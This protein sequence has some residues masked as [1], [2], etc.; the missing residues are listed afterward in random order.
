MIKTSTLVFRILVFGVIVLLVGVT[1]V[2]SID[3]FVDRSYTKP[4]SNP[5]TS[6]TVEVLVSRYKADGTVEKNKVI[7]SK[8]KALEFKE[9]Y[10]KIDDAENSF[11]LL[12]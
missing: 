1:I 7:L 10:I 11:S 8:E 9:R 12:K 6:K 5:M 2:P 4:S 3:A